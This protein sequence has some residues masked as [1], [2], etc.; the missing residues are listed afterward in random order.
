MMFWLKIFASAVAFIFSLAVAQVVGD[1]VRD[2]DG[3]IKELIAFLLAFGI[4]WC[5]I[6]LGFAK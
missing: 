5:G 1:G 4:L 2:C 6:W 3:P